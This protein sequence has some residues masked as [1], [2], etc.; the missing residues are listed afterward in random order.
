MTHSNMKQIAIN[1]G[2]AYPIFARSIELW[3]FYNSLGP[4]PRE[5]ATALTISAMALKFGEM[6]HSIMKP[7]AI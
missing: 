1:N 2:L 5:D 4:G 6:M 7:I 3:I